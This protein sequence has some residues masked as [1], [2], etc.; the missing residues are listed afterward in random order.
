MALI[1]RLF[2]VFFA[3]LL[4]CFAAGTIVVVAV[5]FPEFSDLSMGGTIDQSAINIVLGFGF[6]FLSGFALL[7]ALIVVLIT[8]AFYIRGVLTYAVGGAIV[9]AACYLGL[10]P[11]DTQTMQFDGIVRRH[12]E[13]MTGAGIV[14][15][16][17]YWMISGRSAGNWRE[18]PRPLRPPP[19]LPSQSRPLP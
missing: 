2:V 5:L 15:G 8:E 16:L 1:G 4:A 12:L 11:F 13:I 18:P 6:I 14:A 7:P 10:V 17:V 3:F 9:G 19:P